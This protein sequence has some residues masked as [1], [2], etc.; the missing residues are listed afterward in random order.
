MTGKTKPT[1]V[2]PL[3]AVT[4]IAEKEPEKIWDENDS[5]PANEARWLAYFSQHEAE[6][7]ASEEEFISEYKRRR[8]LAN[9]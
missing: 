3:F 8:D 2:G 5:D 4:E 7:T 9:S 6:M 1:E